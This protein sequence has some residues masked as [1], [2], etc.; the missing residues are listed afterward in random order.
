[1]RRAP[2]RAEPVPIELGDLQL[3]VCNECL[4]AGA[5]C[6]RRGSLRARY[7]QRCFECVDIIGQGGKFGVHTA[8]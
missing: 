5:L 3:Q 8:K 2:T 7:Q 1:V 6:H 4:I